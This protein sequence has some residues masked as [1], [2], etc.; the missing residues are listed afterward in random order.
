MRWFR[1]LFARSSPASTASSDGGALPALRLMG[2]LFLAAFRCSTPGVGAAMLPGGLGLA[3]VIA[4]AVAVVVIGMIGLGW[5]RD[6]S[7]DRHP[8]RHGAGD[9]GGLPWPSGR[10]SRLA[11]TA[12]S[13]RRST[14]PAR[15]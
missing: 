4:N 14:S 1:S 5:L 11:G 3:L 8:L 9:E 15:C 13:T 10:S 6:G 12:V 7:R 2:V